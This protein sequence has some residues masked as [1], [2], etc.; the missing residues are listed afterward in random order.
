MLEVFE[1]ICLLLAEEY[2]TYKHP[3]LSL[4]DSCK[5]MRDLLED[6]HVVW[7]TVRLSIPEDDVSRRVLMKLLKGWIARAGEAPLDYL[8]EYKSQMYH[9]KDHQLLRKVFTMLCECDWKCPVNYIHPDRP[10]K[11]AKKRE[12]RIFGNFLRLVAFPQISLPSS[13]PSS[14][15]LI[16]VFYV[17][18]NYQAIFEYRIDG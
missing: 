4:R 9:D 2:L 18:L 6:M 14:A 13:I 12:T 11:N 3:L 15:W 1:P 8:V 10:V 17:C 7:A 5:A 16:Y